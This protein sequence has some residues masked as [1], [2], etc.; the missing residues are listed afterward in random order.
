MARVE[1]ARRPAAAIFDLDGTLADTFALVFA[2][3][4][5]AMREPTGRQYSPEEIMARFG[6]PDPDMIRRELPHD[7][8]ERAVEVYHDFYA[9]RHEQM[10]NTFDGVREMLDELSKRRV[11]MG[12]VTGKG[13]RTMNVTLHTLG[14]DKHFGVTISGD[15]VERQKPAP[16]ALVLA[17]RALGVE[18]NQC[19][20][21]GDS[22]ADI[23]AGKAAGMLTVAAAWHAP[24]RERIRALEPDVWAE[25]PRDVVRVF[26]D[27][28]T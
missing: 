27:E 25:T 4:N 11:P 9:A 15:D 7:Q 12:I 19:A 2:S 21:I 20:M 14:L 6:V 26:D 28:R 17:A 13:L 24:Y 16:D 10:V 5:E 22:P 3:W 18:P 23:S 8:H 1:P